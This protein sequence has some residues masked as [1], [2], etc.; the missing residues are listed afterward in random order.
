MEHVGASPNLPGQGRPQEGP[1]SGKEALLLKYG[2]LKVHAGVRMDLGVGG[3]FFLLL[4][5]IIRNPVLFEC[6]L[7]MCVHECVW[8]NMLTNSVIGI[9]LV[10]MIKLIK[11]C[12]SVII[13]VHVLMAVWDAVGVCV[14][15]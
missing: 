7:I 5:V 11:K 6:P 14:Q 13:T 10:I 8:V 2:A 12:L 15:T 1:L 4:P 3:R 9:I